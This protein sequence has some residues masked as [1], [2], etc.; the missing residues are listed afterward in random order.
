MDAAEFREE[1]RSV[2]EPYRLQIDHPAMR[3]VFRVLPTFP[4]R[5][6]IALEQHFRF[7][8]VIAN[9]QKVGF[10]VLP[11]VVADDQAAALWSRPR[12]WSGGYATFRARRAWLAKALGVKLPKA[13]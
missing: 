11:A 4:S 5:S 13:E 3:L 7:R 2:L 6:F 9:R 12:L 8:R 10:D 1:H